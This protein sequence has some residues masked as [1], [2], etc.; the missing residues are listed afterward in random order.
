MKYVALATLLS[1]LAV[2][3]KADGF[4]RPS[5]LFV[6][7]TMSGASTTTGV[8]CAVGARLGAQREHEVAFDGLFAK[9]DESTSYAGTSVKG[10]LRYSVL[11]ASYRYYFGR[12]DSVARF[13]IGPA[14]GFA[15]TAV[16]DPSTRM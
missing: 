2:S 8:G 16:G 4:V 11:M 10:D 9:W 13:Y 6:S 1:S 15:S 7:P 3:A 14:V 5:V 12:D